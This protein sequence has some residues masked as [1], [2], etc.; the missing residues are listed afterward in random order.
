MNIKQLQLYVKQQL[1]PFISLEEI[2]SVVNWLIEYR[3]GCNQV[4]VNLNP[5]RE[6]AKNIEDLLQEDIKKL[7][8][9]YPIQYIVGV[10][11]FLNCQIAVNE[12]VLIPRQETEQLVDWMMQENS[13]THP[14]YILDICTGSGCIAIALAKK[15]PDSQ[16]SAIDISSSALQLAKQN[17]VNNHVHVDFVCQ[18]ILQWPKWSGRQ[19]YGLIVSNPPYVLNMEKEQMSPRVLDYEPHVA[20][21]VED[22]KPLLF[23]EQI[24]QFAQDHLLPKGQLFFEINENF[25]GEMIDLLKYYGYQSIVLKQDLNGK[26]RFIKGIKR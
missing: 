26:N 14:N 23:Y 1:T 21:F 13:R 2:N 15:Y 6:I 17:A 22:K 11:E 20:L 5:F 10:V 4:Y 25:G 9:N 7:Q 8:N 12:N 16:V 19:K 3:T 18:D 24:L